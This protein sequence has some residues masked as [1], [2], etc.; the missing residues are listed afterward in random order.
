MS[1]WCAGGT[2]ILFLFLAIT[3]TVLPV[4][5]TRR[6][7]LTIAPL[8]GLAIMALSFLVQLGRVDQ[9]VD[10]ITPNDWTASHSCAASATFLYYGA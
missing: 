6:H 2:L 9:C 7:C 8:M 3:Y 4:T 10:P 1:T 5:E